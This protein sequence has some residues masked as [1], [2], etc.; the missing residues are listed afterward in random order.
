M[1]DHSIG[2]PLVTASQ[3]LIITF[4]PPSGTTSPRKMELRRVI[5]KKP[6]MLSPRGTGDSRKLRV[7]W[8]FMTLS[9]NQRGLHFGIFAAMVVPM[10][11]LPTVGR[12]SQR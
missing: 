12:S 8:A 7:A 4:S 3:G 11:I 1:G 10:L 2:M 9:S 5:A 6:L